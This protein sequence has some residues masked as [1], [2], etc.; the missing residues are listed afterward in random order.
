MDLKSGDEGGGVKTPKKSDDPGGSRNPKLKGTGSFSSKDMIFRADKI[1]LK[2]LDIQLEK[3]LSRVWSRNVDNQRPAEE[4]EID[5][6][7]LD[8]R[9]VVAH[10]TYGTVYRA[11][12]DNQD[13]A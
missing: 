5:L 3:H 13:V 11:T 2:S 10:G 6:A 12:Y 7:K 1:D 4:W 8:L 9:H